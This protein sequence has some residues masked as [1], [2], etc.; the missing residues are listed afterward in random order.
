VAHRSH[1]LVVAVAEISHLALA[2]LGALVVVAQAAQMRLE[3]RVQPTS[4]V[5]VVV[6]VLLEAIQGLLA[7]QAAQ[8]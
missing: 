4:A 3:L 8:A 5:A 7:A 2:V 1:T 6:A